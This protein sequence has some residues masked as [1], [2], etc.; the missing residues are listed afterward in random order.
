MYQAIAVQE[1]LHQAYK[2]I[3]VVHTFV[4]LTRRP[5]LLRLAVCPFFYPGVF[6]FGCLHDV[7]PFGRVMVALRRGRKRKL[8]EFEIGMNTL[9]FVSEVRNLREFGHQAT[10]CEDDGWAGSKS[11]TPPRERNL[12]LG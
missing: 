12:K 3:L 5:P 6:P 4:I 1:Y 11:L 10:G 8:F 9:H 2:R 7:L